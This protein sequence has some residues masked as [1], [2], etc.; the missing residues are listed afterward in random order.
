MFTIRRWEPFPAFAGVQRDLDR[1]FDEFFRRPLV[2]RGEDGVRTP[3]VDIAETADEVLVTAE[4]PGIDREQLE[5]EVTPESLSLR[6]ERR[7]ESEEEGTSFR[8]RERVWGRYERT[9]PLPAE[10]LSDKAEA[11][12]EDG[13]LR[14]RIPKTETAKPEVPTKVKVG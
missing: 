14:I 4:V 6:A 9:V 11:K 8:R 1:L 2:R 7:A 5:V 13:V 3:S 12:L 10:V